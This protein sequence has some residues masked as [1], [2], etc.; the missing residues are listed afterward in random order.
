MF[1]FLDGPVRAAVTALY[2]AVGYL[3]VTIWVVIE[4]VIAPI[5]S[6]LVLPFAG[7]LA[8]EATAIEPLTGAFWSPTLLVV[9]ATVGSLLGGLLT[10]ALGA[11]VGRPALI[12]ARRLTGVG[13][14]E[15][16]RVESWFVRY[17]IWAALLGRMVPLLRSLV[18]YAAGLG[19]MPL[20]PYLV[21]TVLGS[22]PF[23][24]LLIGAGVAMGA[25]WETISGPLKAAERGILL[26]LVLLVALLALRWWWARRAAR[27]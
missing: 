19:R 21:G 12:A 4:T 24:A 18:G 5:P 20:L 6:E 27:P 10:Y 3:G 2:E 17:G 15:L 1:E 23:N 26:A 7:F 11:V 25:N 22:L 13:E 16:A 8:G 14:A 9:A